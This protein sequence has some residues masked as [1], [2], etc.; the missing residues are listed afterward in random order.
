M[1]LQLRGIDCG[2][3]WGCPSL[4]LRAPRERAPRAARTVAAA[5]AEEALEPEEP[6]EPLPS[7]HVPLPRTSKSALLAHV[8]A[9]TDASQQRRLV[10]DSRLRELA[11]VRARAAQL[12]AAAARARRT[13]SAAQAADLFFVDGYN[14][15]HAWPLLKPLMAAGRLEAA[16]ERLVTE[17]HGLAHYRGGHRYV[18]V[19]DAQ[20]TPLSE[21]VME[22]HS[23][24]VQVVFATG[25]DGTADSFIER[26]AVVVSRSEPH[27]R[28]TVV[29]DDRALGALSRGT[30]ALNISSQ[31]LI[32]MMQ[33]SDEDTRNVIRKQKSKARAALAGGAAAPS[34]GGPSAQALSALRAK[35]NEQ[36]KLQHVQAQR[37]KDK[38]A[39]TK[40]A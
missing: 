11:S 30:G 18:V 9:Q 14:V 23:S 27:T 22:Q 36:A 29:S 1:G 38:I 15:C 16:R 33:K 8:R 7:V 28:V 17:V 12:D 13:K 25:G 37:A 20:A 10:E 32:I 31:E 3:G 6:S 2:G 34:G 39:P 4:T 5:A 21:P 35:L 40:Q 19:F 26:E 24:L